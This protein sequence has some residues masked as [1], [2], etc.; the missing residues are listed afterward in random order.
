M[1][2][3][4]NPVEAKSVEGEEDKKKSQS[5]DGGACAEDRQGLPTDVGADVVAAPAANPE[6]A[7][8]P[9]RVKKVVMERTVSTPRTVDIDSDPL[10]FAKLSV[11][12]KRVEQDARRRRLSA[13]PIV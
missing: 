6:K 11:M 12:S 8:K 7:K 4:S 2:I 3:T 5:S 10:F 9:A 1:D 13:M